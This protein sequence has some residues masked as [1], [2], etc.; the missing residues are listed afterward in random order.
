MNRYSFRC[1]NCKIS[2]GK[3]SE[4]FPEDVKCPDC[5][6]ENIECIQIVSKDDKNGF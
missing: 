1:D 2:F 6:S 5:K 3:D 4:R